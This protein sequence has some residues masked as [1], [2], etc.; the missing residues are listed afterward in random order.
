MLLLYTQV[1][2]DAG[3][4]L[5]YVWKVPKSPAVSS[6]A[7][8]VRGVAFNMSAEGGVQLCAGCSSGLIQVRSPTAVASSVLQ[9]VSRYTAADVDHGKT[10]TI[11]LTHSSR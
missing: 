9:L 5:L 8:F 4:N 1:W 3:V 7:D 6:H 11:Y 10:N 2:D